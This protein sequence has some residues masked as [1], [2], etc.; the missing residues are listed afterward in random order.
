MTHLILKQL[1]IALALITVTGFILRW[2]WRMA[3]STRAGS[4]WTK[5][6]PHVIDTLF[7]GS[8]ILLALSVAQYPLSHAW[9]TAKVG[10]LLLYIIIGVIAMRTAPRW[11]VSVPALVAALLVFTWI[12]SVAR[13][14]SPHGFFI[15]L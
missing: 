7:L 10:G 4:R 2:S 13:L 6:L 3:G 12:V 8:G 15:L 1:H 5:S 14:R 11:Q 9:L